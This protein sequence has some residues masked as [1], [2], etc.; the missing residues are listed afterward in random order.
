M[1][2]R[3]RLTDY[4][5]R[6]ESEGAID[7][8]TDDGQVF[9]IPPPELWPDSVGKLVRENDLV[10]LGEAL[11]GADGYARFVEAGGSAVI[12]NGIFAEVHGVDVGERR[13]SPP[14]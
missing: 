5:E 1:A 4:K 6:K 9:R 12:L 13:A 10:G 11:L 7:V 8:E 14:S 3:I 2:T